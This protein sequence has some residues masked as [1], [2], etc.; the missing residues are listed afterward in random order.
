MIIKDLNK[1]VKETVRVNIIPHETWLNHYQ[2]LWS[3]S[4]ETLQIPQ[5][6]NFNRETITLDELVTVLK[7]MKNNKAPEV[8]SVNVKLFKYYCQSFL[9]RFLNF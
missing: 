7:N 8:D 5:S 1:E 9:K 4:S 6:V 2:G 3:Q